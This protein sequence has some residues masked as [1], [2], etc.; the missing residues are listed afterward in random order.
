MENTQ[1]NAY[2]AAFKLKAIDLSVKEGNRAAAFKL[3]IHGKY[4]IYL[5]YQ[6]VIKSL[7]KSL[8]KYLMLQHGHL[9]L[10]DKSTYM[11]V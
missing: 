3:G 4:L 1:R 10:I 8:C 9:R 7:K 5:S 11:C 6:Y 2:D